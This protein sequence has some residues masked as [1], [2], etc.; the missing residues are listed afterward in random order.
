MYEMPD[1]DELD[2]ATL[3]LCRTCAKDKTLKEFIAANAGGDTYCGVCLSP[4]TKDETCKLERKGDLTNLLKS[5]VRFHF[6]ESDYNP[7]WGGE[8]SPANLLYG[9]NPIVHHTRPCSIGETRSGQHLFEIFSIAAVSVPRP[10]CRSNAG[11]DDEGANA[12]SVDFARR[13]LVILVLPSGLFSETI[14]MFEPDVR[15]FITS[16]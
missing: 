5:L 2:P 7:H 6:D 3:S 10:V 15:K 16:R 14:S 8:N 12:S 1:L 11:F 9:E 4:H 13:E